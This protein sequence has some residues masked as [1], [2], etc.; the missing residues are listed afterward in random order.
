MDSENYADNSA[1]QG[2]LHNLAT[3]LL[4]KAATA[5]AKVAHGNGD[6]VLRISVVGCGPGDNDILAIK[7]IILPSIRAYKKD[8]NIMILFNDLPGN[9]WDNL[10]TR[11]CEAF[12]SDGSPNRSI[13]WQLYGSDLNEAFAQ[14]SSVHLTVSFS[15][16]HWIDHLPFD[17]SGVS[18]GAICYVDLP[19]T[20]KDQL[21]RHKDAR[22]KDFI[23][24]RKRELVPGGQM[25]LVFDGET[26]NRE[27][28]YYQPTRLLQQSIQS[29][30][31]KKSLSEEVLSN[32]FVMT[33]SWSA[34]RIQQCCQQ[35]NM[36]LHHLSVRVVPCP[37]YDNFL[38][39][40]QK[41][42][43]RNKFGDQVAD[44]I[45][46]CVRP[47]LAKI[48]KTVGESGDKVDETIH[49]IHKRV[50]HLAAETPASSNT[51]GTVAFVHVTKPNAS[52]SRNNWKWYGVALALI[53]GTLL[54]SR[55]SK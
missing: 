47:Q 19:R 2:T 33:S 17:Q 53:S 6:D 5:A 44:A 51:S 34:P 8:I 14:P 41:A 45:L 24:K 12:E 25:V 30:V 23:L 39:S 55:K 37:M 13:K 38:L 29:M 50:A 36:N 28:Q 1:P 46:S 35:T 9:G 49:A 40:P 20:Q 31:A 11:A 54:W 7:N 48:I 18:N 32:F 10:H 26:A 16:L 3:N 43:D 21:R 4:Q 52:D 15:A 42:E 22:L 27:H